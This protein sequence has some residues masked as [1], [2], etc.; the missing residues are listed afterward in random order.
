MWKLK[1]VRQLS[2]NII[3][4]LT[5]L[6]TNMCWIFLLIDNN[7]LLKTF[8]IH[9]NVD[10]QRKIRQ[11]IWL[12]I[13]LYI[14]PLEMDHQWIRQQQ[15]H[16]PYIAAIVVRVRDLYE[17]NVWWYGTWWYSCHTQESRCQRQKSMV[18]IFFKWFLGKLNDRYYVT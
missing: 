18:Q 16:A 11:T 17:F 10:E 9:D 5:L 2:T 15:K 7:A 12:Y 1:T 14:R 6:F 8:Y 4:H 3:K 13:E